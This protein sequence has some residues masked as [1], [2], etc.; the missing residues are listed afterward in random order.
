[1]ESRKTDSAL[2]ET[3]VF[4]AGRRRHLHTWFSQNSTPSVRDDVKR[5]EANNENHCRLQAAKTILGKQFPEERLQDQK[6]N[7]S[8]ANHP[9]GRDTVQPLRVVPGLCH[10]FHIEPCNGPLQHS[11][12]AENQDEIPVSGRRPLGPPEIRALEGLL[13]LQDEEADNGAGREEETESEEN[14]RGSCA[15]HRGHERESQESKQYAEE[16]GG[17]HNLV[18]STQ[19]AGT[20]II[21]RQQNPSA[22]NA[23]DGP[24]SGTPKSSDPSLLR[25]IPLPL[26]SSH[27][28]H[29][30][31]AP[32][33][34]GKGQ[35]GEGQDDRQ[36]H[37]RVNSRGVEKG[38]RH[39]YGGEVDHG[40]HKDATQ[41][42]PLFGDAADTNVVL[43]RELKEEND[44]Q[45][46]DRNQQSDFADRESEDY[47]DEDGAQND[48]QEKASRNFDPSPE[49]AFSTRHADAPSTSP[50]NSASARNHTGLSVSGEPQSPG[51][52]P[53]FALQARA[54]PTF[55]SRVKP[56]HPI[57]PLEQ[58]EFRADKVRGPEGQLCQQEPGAEVHQVRNES[59]RG[60]HQRRQGHIVGNDFASH[61][62]TAMESDDEKP[63]CN[64]QVREQKDET[65][66]QCGEK[67]RRRLSENAREEAG[68]GNEGEKGD[69]FPSISIHAE[70]SI[71]PYRHIPSAHEEGDNSCAESENHDSQQG[72]FGAPNP[73]GNKAR[74]LDTT[75][76]NRV[77]PGRAARSKRVLPLPRVQRGAAGPEMA[78]TTISSVVRVYSDAMRPYLSEGTLVRKGR[79]LRTIARDLKTS[80]APSKL[81]DR[82]IE[83]L[84]LAW[85][86]RGLDAA[87]QAKYLVDLMHWL[88]RYRLR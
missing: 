55:P 77:D 18:G 3:P 86:S 35:Y 25:E 12:S 57:Q 33:N 58:G 53:E 43:E 72:A 61:F 26:S 87:T 27:P 50:R 71:P 56:L 67:E 4:G 9:Y 59:P 88:D 70:T 48:V 24:V 38:K 85:R 29:N 52:G 79:N 8:P 32:S 13:C 69:N 65:K 83:R 37:P 81:G 47:G 51:F 45:R 5:Y 7:Q 80:V 34:H 10:P 62:P 39:S 20:P 40:K 17:Q 11:L 21:P 6:P 22:G 44:R 42:S 41:A 19:H 36:P 28:P 73:V 54:E 2:S 14:R 23:Q 46:H 68:W 64:S 63:R 75:D 82:E 15:R 16:G 78:R 66:P 49:T 30:H 31:E 74:K 60:E 1:M 76:T 84:L